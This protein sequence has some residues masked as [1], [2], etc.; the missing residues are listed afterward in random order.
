MANLDSPKGFQVI[1]DINGGGNTNFQPYTVDS[2]NATAIF[3]G[4]PIT[5][6]ADGNVKP[7]AAGDGVSVAAVA[8][9]FKDS[10]GNSIKFL[11]ALTGGTIGGLPVKGQVFSI[12]SDSGTVVNAT[13]INATVDFVA[14]TGDQTTG[15]SRYELDSSN[16][17]TGQQL[18]MLGKVE[19]VGQDN[20]FGEEHV[21][22][23]VV[24]VENAY[25]DNTSI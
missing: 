5:L 21:N 23:K 22:T 12:Q 2:A 17:G 16:I 11:P 9:T 14:G 3:Q 18:R 6:E 25:E 24:F 15:R 19:S 13:D 4:D 7:S 20:E 8:H 10:D 1:D